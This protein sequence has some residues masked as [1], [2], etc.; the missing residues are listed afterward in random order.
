[1]DTGKR[2]T[3]DIRDRAYRL[4]TTV[5]LQVH[6]DE[7]RY[8]LRI[9]KVAIGLDIQLHIQLAILKQLYT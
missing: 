6:G 5:V 8:V 7:P 1:M 3:H 9:D 4:S 2:G